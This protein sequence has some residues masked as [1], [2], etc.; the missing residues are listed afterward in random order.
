MNLKVLA[1]LILYYSVLSIFILGSGDILTDDGLTSDIN[2]SSIDVSEE[3]DTGG[4]FG[5]GISFGRFFGLILFGI[6]LP[7]SSPTWLMLLWGVW[8]TGFT[9]FGIGWFINSIWGG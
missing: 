2:M 9:I 1:L 3:T 8:Q 4:L 7:A 5:T 6:G